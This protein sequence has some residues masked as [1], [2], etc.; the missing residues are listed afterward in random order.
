MVS[1]RAI[2][3]V[4]LLASPALAAEVTPIQKVIEMMDGMLAKGKAMKHEEEVQFAKFKAWCDS[5]RAETTKNIAAAADAI[6]QLAADIDKAESD[7]EVLAGEVKELEAE[8]ASNKASADSA[9]AERKKEHEAYAAEHLDLEES[10]SA[11]AKAI[12]VLKSKSADTAQSASLLQVK[13]LKLVPDSAKAVLESFLSTSEEAGAPE[14]NAYEFQSGGVVAM[15][16]KLKIKFEDQKLGL[17]KEEMNAKANYQ[18]LMQQL[19]DDI[20]ADKKSADSKTAAKAGRLEDAA[21][22]KGDKV[23]TEKSK[24]TDESTLS[25]TTAECTQESE[26]FENNQV[27]RANE[28]EAIEKAISILSS[29]E[30]SGA[31]EKHLPSAAL[32]QKKKTAFAQLRSSVKEAPGS[33][34]RAVNYLQ[35]QASKIG[36]KYLAVMA[37]HAQDDP[38]GK[39]KKMIKDL[40]TKLM[41]EA[42]SEADQHGYCQ[43]ELATNKQTRE[44]KSS[45]VEELSSNID[46]ETAT[47]EQLT[48]DIT[49]LSDAISAI[50]GQQLEATKIRKAEKD[51]NAVAVSDAQV[52]QKAVENAIKVLKDFYASQSGAALLQKAKKPEGVEE[53]KGMQAGSGGILGM[54]D[55]VLSDFARLETETSEAEAMA[56]AAYEKFMDESAEDTAVKETELKHKSN[57]KDRCLEKLRGLK[58]EL[59]LTQ[60]ELDSAM[61]Y[62]DKLKSQCVDTGLSYEERK[63]MREEE[64]VSLQEALKILNGEDLA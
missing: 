51:T 58:K 56:V 41:E 62:Y 44:I 26:E 11:L 14:A 29:D 61:E 39:V 2:L 9:S 64:L 60:T 23:V 47:S 24:A 46:L 40:I 4:G 28:I 27:V 8:I 33:R 22:A 6:E 43:T 55:V 12:M 49:T 3:L 34:Q 35:Q 1:F 32:L 30:V 25:D 31:G 13:K 53:Y 37:S 42:N 59:E 52:A 21:S 19:T 45:E 16:E 48:S 7:A 15:L 17:E 63:K 38:F 54:L 50:K 18:T 20:K 36:S 5:T 57:K 10:L